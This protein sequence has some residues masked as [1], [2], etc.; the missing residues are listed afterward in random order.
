M[1]GDANVVVRPEPAAGSA[2]DYNGV[3]R[4]EG[5]LAAMG[6]PIIRSIVSDALS[7]FISAVGGEEKQKRAGWF[8][9]LAQMLR[10]RWRRLRGR[11]D[12]SV[13]T[14]VH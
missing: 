4:I 12:P 7:E 11:Q 10:E 5:S 2:L 6:G 8:G 14:R 3:I 13:V 9:R 1:D